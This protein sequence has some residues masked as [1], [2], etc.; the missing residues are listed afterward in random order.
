VRAHLP[1]VPSGD[2]SVLVDGVLYLGTR[3][4]LVGL[5]GVDGHVTVSV[6]TGAASVEAV[7]LWGGIGVFTTRDPG[8][9][10]GFE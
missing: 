8:L 7:V 6:E 1:V 5:D 4:R 10:V 9:V 3:N 2:V